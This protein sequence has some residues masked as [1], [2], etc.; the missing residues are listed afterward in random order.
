MGFT[1][2]MCTN[3]QQL[4]DHIYSCAHSNKMKAGPGEGEER[5]RQKGAGGDEQRKRERNER[6]GMGEVWS[7]GM[8]PAPS[9]PSLSP[10]EKP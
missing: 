4:C 9:P 10:Y 2:G 7:F 6:G 5:E 3:H 1:L 8:F